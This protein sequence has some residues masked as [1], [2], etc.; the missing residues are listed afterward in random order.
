ML[1]AAALVALPAAAQDKGHAAFVAKAKAVVTK[2]FKD[3]EGA[4]Y[5]NLGVYRDTQGMQTL[6]GEVNAKNSYGAYVGYRSFYVL[7]TNVTFREDGDDSLFD[8]LRPAY[9]KKKIADAK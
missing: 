1:I 4:R 3:P 5:R 7:E 9:C 6:C 8:A 2:D